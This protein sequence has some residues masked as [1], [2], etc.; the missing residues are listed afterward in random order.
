LNIIGCDKAI[1]VRADRD[2]INRVFTNLIKNAVEAMPDGGELTVR[3][4]KTDGGAEF[5]FKDTGVG[6]TAEQLDR[7]FT[8]YFTSKSG[9]TGL[10][11]SIARRILTDHGARIEAAGAPGRGAEFVVAFGAQTSAETGGS[12]FER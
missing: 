1:I 9:G 11:L 8:P 4:E 7:I 12:G 6:I 10:G 3:A 2:Q 5:R